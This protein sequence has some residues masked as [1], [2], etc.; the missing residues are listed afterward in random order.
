[1]STELASLL[2]SSGLK[3]KEFVVLCFHK[4]KWAVVAMF[5]VLKAGAAFVHVDLTY[6]PSRIFFICSSSGTRLALCA[7]Q[8][9][10][11]LRGHV[12]EMLLLPISLHRLPLRQHIK[13]NE[14]DPS[15]PGFL[16][17]TSGSSGVPK[18]QLSIS[19]RSVLA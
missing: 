19:R 3:P 7:D 15:H 10:H 13:D 11:A 2:A 1:M 5:A 6:P 18:E 4:S 17:Y 12:K 8:T 16:I 9:A 14:A